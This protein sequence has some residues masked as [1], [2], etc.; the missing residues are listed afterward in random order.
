MSDERRC[1]QCGHPMHEPGASACDTWP[2]AF[3]FPEERRVA[4][5]DV[6]PGAKEVKSPGDPRLTAIR[7][8]QKALRQMVADMRAGRKMPK[9]KQP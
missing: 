5:G 2:C 9:P 1:A 6:F 4:T 7:E 8:K 3:P